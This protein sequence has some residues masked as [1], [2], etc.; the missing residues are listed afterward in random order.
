MPRYSRDPRVI[1]ARFKSVC[2]ETGRT[3]AKGDECVYYPSS[4]EA[5]HMDSPSGKSARDMLADDVLMPDFDPD[6]LG[7]CNY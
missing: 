7:P 5:F 3:I 6:S 2:P 4:R 1:T